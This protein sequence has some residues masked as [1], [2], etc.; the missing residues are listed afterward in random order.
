MTEIKGVGHIMVQGSFWNT[1]TPLLI[2]NVLY[3][4]GLTNNLLS[5]VMLKEAGLEGKLYE[6]GLDL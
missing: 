3:A 4:P 6:S 2:R 5:G 1:L